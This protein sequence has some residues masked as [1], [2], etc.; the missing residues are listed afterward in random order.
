MKK[1]LFTCFLAISAL[2]YSQEEKKDSIPSKWN[3][4]GQFTFLFNQSS[5]SNW[6]AGGEN[7]VAGNVAIDYDFNFK[8]KSWNWDNRIRTIFGLSNVM[9]TGFRKNYATPPF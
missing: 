8:N 2:A 1:L 3:V 7:T 9:S 6:K 4:T 5:F